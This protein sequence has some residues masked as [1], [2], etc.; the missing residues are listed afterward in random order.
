[1]SDTRPNHIG[2]NFSFYQS[3]NLFV[4]FVIILSISMMNVCSN[5]V[6]SICL[7]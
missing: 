6:N 5:V 7:R 3:I 2:C 1:M 4:P